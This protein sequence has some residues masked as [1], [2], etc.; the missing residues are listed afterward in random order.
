MK[1]KRTLPFPALFAGVVLACAGPVS[2]WADNASTVDRVVGSFSSLCLSE[3]LEMAEE[4]ARN[5]DYVLV[6]DTVNGVVWATAN[7]G[8]PEGLTAD[9]RISDSQCE[10]RY[11]GAP[12]Y[13]YE[14]VSG[15]LN[16]AASVVPLAH[17]TN[18]GEVALLE[19]F[20]IPGGETNVVLEVARKTD[21]E[22]SIGSFRREFVKVQDDR[23]QW[24]FIRRAEGNVA[25]PEAVVKV[26]M[27]RLTV[28]NYLGTTKMIFDPHFYRNE[29]MENQDAA[30]FMR[31]RSIFVDG[32]SFD[33]YDQCLNDQRVC[34]KNGQYFAL[35]LEPQDVATLKNANVIELDAMTTGKEDYRFVLGMRG[36]SR[37]LTQALEEG[38]QM[39]KNLVL[40]SAVINDELSHIVRALD[41]GADPGFVLEND[42]SLLEYAVQN[43]KM[44]IASILVEHG[45]DVNRTSTDGRGSVTTLLISSAHFTDDVDLMRRVLSLNPDTEI[46][47][48]DGRTAFL[49]TVNY[50]GSGVRKF[51]LLKQHGANL[52]VTDND[53]WTAFHWEASN[54]FISDP[55]LIL[56]W[57]KR[58]GLDMN[59][60]DNHGNTPLHI[61][62]YEGAHQSA[63]Q[64]I[65]LGARYDI[66]N[67]KG[68]DARRLARRLRNEV[69]DDFV[70][71]PK[72]EREN[73]DQL[74]REMN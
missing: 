19:R 50:A 61:A 8:G 25:L 32:R 35:D 74:M 24:Q 10:F 53:G 52:Y 54:R 43:N 12:A 73:L 21:G 33:A 7:V 28:H 62:L 38:E 17:L 70:R 6:G 22:F 20:M 29:G 71:D 64:L 47:D 49:R 9:L 55:E 60:Q 44:T 36:S 66:R 13:L 37:V 59:A 11:P 48:Q 3:P 39:G 58:Q 51:E 57:L 31:Q 56:G 45:A 30:Y 63:Q 42:V 34:I 26:G 65:R 68:E 16:D 15:V 4:S 46:R 72:I 67:D 2:V 41:N 69:P 27:H 14:A 40:T 23:E 5:A 18:Q 1:M